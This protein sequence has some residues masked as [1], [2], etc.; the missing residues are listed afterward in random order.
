MMVKT[1]KPN[2]YTIDIQNIHIFYYSFNFDFILT[3]RLHLIPKSCEM[4]CHT[5]IIQMREQF[6]LNFKQTWK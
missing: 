5:I 2:V 1:Q 6:G 4:N 3:F